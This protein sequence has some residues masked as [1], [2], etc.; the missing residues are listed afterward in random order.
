MLARMTDP[1]D[2][3]LC[4]LDFPAG[5]DATLAG[6]ALITLDRPDKLNALSFDAPPRAGRAPRSPRR[7][8]DVSR[9]RDH[10]RR[11]PCLRGRRRHPRARRPDAR[12]APRRRPL[13]GAGRDRVAA[14]AG[15]RGRPWLRARRRL[16]LAL[17]CDLVV[18]GDDAQLGF[19]E[20]GPRRHPRG[21][22]HARLARA[23]GRAK[24]MEAVL[25]VAGSAQPGGAPRSRVPGRP[26]AE[27]LDRALELGAS[28]SICRVLAQPAC[29][30][31]SSICSVQ[32]LKSLEVLHGEAVKAFAEGSKVAADFL[33]AYADQKR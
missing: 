31:R 32:G 12:V 30:P 4:I 27:T 17:A 18:A 15:D 13:R 5:P 25:T 9:G 26:A 23:I 8:S 7:R 14:D 29:S 1:A 19:P 20:P 16:R 24:A 22:R 10:G 21:R 11:G 3:P 2:R 33:E 6:V 28:T